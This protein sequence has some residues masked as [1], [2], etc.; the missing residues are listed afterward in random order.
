[1]TVAIFVW[2]IGSLFSHF[3]TFSFHQRKYTSNPVTRT[4]Q[5]CP[6]CGWL[7]FS[8]DGN[9]HGLYLKQIMLWFKVSGATFWNEHWTC[10]QCLYM[11][12]GATYCFKSYVKQQLKQQNFTTTTYSRT[13]VN[14]IQ[15]VVIS[16]KQLQWPHFP[17][18]KYLIVYGD[19]YLIC[20]YCLCIT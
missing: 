13:P 7:Y 10:I 12:R 15:L 14:V 6:H 16:T 9:Y 19:I 3:M 20:W 4:F 8:C 17:I 11:K 5:S 2:N 18:L 1:M